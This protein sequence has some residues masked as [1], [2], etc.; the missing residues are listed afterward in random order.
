MPIYGEWRNP[1]L[2]RCD[3]KRAFPSLELAEKAAQRLSLRLNEL[4]IAYPC[5]DCGRHHVGHADYSQLLIRMAPDGSHRLECA[6]CKGPISD[7]RR[8][9]L[10]FEGQ[11]AYCCSPKCQR[12]WAKKKR[13]AK[14][15]AETIDN[16]LNDADRF[17]LAVS[18]ISGK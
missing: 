6:N 7:E 16:L 8:A 12:K 10:A 17:M 15:K 5:F 9:T 13:H 1:A 2:K 4:L 18:Q 11:V 3:P 14:R